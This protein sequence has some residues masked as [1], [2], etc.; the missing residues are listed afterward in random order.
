MSNFTKC[1]N[2]KCENTKPD[3][4]RTCDWPWLQVSRETEPDRDFCS[5]QCLAIWAAPGSTSE[6]L[7]GVRS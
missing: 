2:P 6:R 7:T 3:V 5:K 4:R 1:D